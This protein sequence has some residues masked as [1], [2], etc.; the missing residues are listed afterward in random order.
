MSG[1]AV[2]SQLSS[3][4]HPLYHPHCTQIHK[5]T[6]A[7]K[8]YYTNTRLVWQDYRLQIQDY[9]FRIKDSGLKIQDY[10][11]YISHFSLFAL[12]PVRNQKTLFT[13]D[14]RR[15]DLNKDAFA[16]FSLRPG[17]V[18]ILSNQKGTIFF[19]F[20]FQEPETGVLYPVT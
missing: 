19:V 8:Q 10:S 5:Y 13:L 20:Q 7:Q 17:F 15:H 1:M 9:R 18:A 6:N 11:C 3:K 14:P 2:P 4:C 16:T 12:S